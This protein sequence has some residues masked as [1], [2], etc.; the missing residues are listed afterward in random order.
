M[1][2][3][4]SVSLREQLFI[5]IGRG[6]DVNLDVPLSIRETEVFEYSRLNRFYLR[7]DNQALLDDFLTFL[8]PGLETKRIIE[9]LV[10]TWYNG[11]WNNEST[12]YRQVKGWLID[13]AVADSD[14]FLSLFKLGFS[15]SGRGSA[16][17]EEGAEA[18]QAVTTCGM[19]NP[20]IQA[21]L[22]SEQRSDRV[23]ALLWIRLSA[24]YDIYSQVAPGH[25]AF[26][27]TDAPE[28]IR[29]RARELL[30]TIRTLMADSGVSRSQFGCIL[31]EMRDAGLL[32][33]EGSPINT[34]AWTCWPGS[35]LMAETTTRGRTGPV[36][37]NYRL[38]TDFLRD[39]ITNNGA[40]AIYQHVICGYCNHSADDCYCGDRVRAHGRRFSI[41]QAYGRSDGLRFHGGE[42]LKRNCLVPRFVGCELE[43]S[44]FDSGIFDS[45]RAS[46]VAPIVEKTTVLERRVA[47][48]KD[49]L[50]ASKLV[51]SVRLWGAG[52]KFDGSLS[53]DDARE[54][55]LAP[56]RSGEAL[57]Q[58]RDITDG[59]RREGAFVTN[60]AGGH[61]HVD[62]EGLNTRHV[63]AVFALWYLLEEEV[64]DRLAPGRTESQYCSP[65]E[66]NRINTS[67]GPD[68]GYS[69]ISIRQSR[70][71]NP[72]ELS[73]NQSWSGGT[74]A[75]FGGLNRRY[76]TLNKSR[77][78][79]TGNMFSGTLEFRLFPGSVSYNRTIVHAGVASKIVDFAAN[80]SREK[81]K[82]AYGKGTEDLLEMVVGSRLWRKMAALPEL[83]FH[84]ESDVIRWDEQCGGS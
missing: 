6:T 28:L 3:A 23:E 80:N 33:V 57:K 69:G 2:E 27:V 79:R 20:D 54:I 78:E 83:D 75:L 68:A 67:A 15:W 26:F 4:R 44:G 53:R 12:S 50:E 58:I 32:A 35:N 24:R 51:R 82:E 25:H 59:L 52:I 9:C 34:P 46:Y 8:P 13:K 1:S 49:K 56:C 48:S 72:E 84:P 64:A 11:C 31:R 76:Q 19:L 71:F 47:K 60:E 41:D 62:L 37:Y 22:S 40:E 29:L 77:A 7:P 42:P 16:F 30:V 61:V 5:M 38:V 55:V 81:L 39:I 70:Q 66:A 17:A 73:Q 10:T 65:M 36:V 63:N 43:I 14:F 74:N 21:R 18:L 45:S